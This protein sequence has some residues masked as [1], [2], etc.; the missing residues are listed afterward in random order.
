MVAYEAMT[1]KQA[2]ALFGT[3]KDIALALGVSR[4][5]IYMWPDRLAQHDVDRVV[6]AALRLG[7]AGPEELLALGGNRRRGKR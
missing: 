4:Q 3:P 2:I 5:R 1:K 7:V 6:G